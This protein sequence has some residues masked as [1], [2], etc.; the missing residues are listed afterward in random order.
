[1]FKITV[2]T[3]KITFIAKEKQQLLGWLDKNHENGNKGTRMAKNEEK[4]EKLTLIANDE[5]RKLGSSIG[6]VMLLLT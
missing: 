3:C 4:K 1:M 5:L 6:C 2:M